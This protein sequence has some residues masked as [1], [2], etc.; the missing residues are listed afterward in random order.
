LLSSEVKPIVLV[1]PSSR[2]RTSWST[3]PPLAS[4]RANGSPS[5]LLPWICNRSTRD[6]RSRRRLA[7]SEPRTAAVTGTLVASTTP[8]TPSSASPM[9]SSDSPFP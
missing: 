1:S 7:S 9:I 4:S 6:R 2:S 3:M 5:K 8:E